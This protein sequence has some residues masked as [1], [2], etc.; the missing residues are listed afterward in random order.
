MAGSSKPTTEN[1]QG[2]LGYIGDTA[3][4]YTFKP[5]AVIGKK[6]KD[7]CVDAYSKT[8]N[9]ASKVWYCAKTGPILSWKMLKVGTKIL[10]F[11]FNAALAD[12]SL[13]PNL[14]ALDDKIHFVDKLKTN[15]GEEATS[16]I[17]PA[18][19]KAINAASAS[20]PE[21]DKKDPAKEPSLALKVLNLLLSDTSLPPLVKELLERTNFKEFLKKIL[22]EEITA[23]AEQTAAKVLQVVVPDKVIYYEGKDGKGVDLN[24]LHMQPKVPLPKED[25]LPKEVKLAPQTTPPSKLT[26]N[27]IQQRTQNELKPRN[28]QHNL[29]NA[30]EYAQTHIYPVIANYATG[31]FLLTY[32]MG[33]PLREGDKNHNED[34]MAVVNKLRVS[35]NNKFS[36]SVFKQVLSERGIKISL[37]QQI[38]LYLVYPLFFRSWITNIIVSSFCNKGLGIIYDQLFGDHGKNQEKLLENS[39]NQ[40]SEFLFK[41]ASMLEEYRKTTTIDTPP[42]QF[43]K[44]FIKSEDLTK[45]YSDLTSTIMNHFIPSIGS[46]LFQPELDK[47]AQKWK[48]TKDSTIFQKSIFF[49]ATSPLRIF[50][51]IS[52]LIETPIRKIIRSLITDIGPTIT[53]STLESMQHP[54]F[55]LNLTETILTQLIELKKDLEDNDEIDT[56]RLPF[57]AAKNPKI[58]MHLRK[59]SEN[60]SKILAN[61]QVNAPDIEERTLLENLIQA[62]DKVG[63]LNLG[64]KYIFDKIISESLEKIIPQAC[65]SILNR[66]LHPREFTDEI[67]TRLVDVGVQ[68]FAPT[69]EFDLAAQK[70]S[71]EVEKKL[72]SVVND[73][74]KIAV[75]KSMQA[76]IDED[77]KPKLPQDLEF[78]EVS[79][80]GIPEDKLID[81]ASVINSSF[82]PRIRDKYIMG[83]IEC[84][85]DENIEHYGIIH[86]LKIITSLGNN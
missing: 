7:V 29:S 9:V 84:I 85:F 30:K 38:K 36:L 53:Q 37:W 13:P 71:T 47:Q 68:A 64:E 43:I 52:W 82:V 62:L 58:H 75:K 67:F 19:A 10:K 51:W 11:T 42:E 23:V 24:P 35:D 3:Y 33:I 4:K 49:I 60:I 16:I 27:L 70:R 76:I 20:T 5:V 40:I 45:L 48:I 65:L 61:K 44:D 66:Y 34:I 21:K 69:P 39:F 81:L 50:K 26:Q 18:L 77:I 2:W 57:S 46:S 6:G 54:I 83:G 41:F 74:T 15:I 73:L 59:M 17:L 12:S 28:I 56:H 8:S 14:K 63:N 80:N 55:Q 78:P 31:Y 79:K 72:K 1:K 22:G 86:A 32:V 25:H